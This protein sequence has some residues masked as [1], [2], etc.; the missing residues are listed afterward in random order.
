[1]MPK[2]VN[3]KSTPYRRP[4]SDLKVTYV[5]FPGTGVKPWGPPDLKVW[6]QKVT[7]YL[8]EVGGIGVG[9]KLHEWP[10]PVVEPVVPAVPV[11][12]P[13]TVPVTGTAPGVPGNGV[14]PATGTGAVDGSAKGK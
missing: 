13:V 7:E 14:A 5:I 10:K 8:N 12:A 11:V 2:A 1:M 9:Y 4:E 6:E 3:E